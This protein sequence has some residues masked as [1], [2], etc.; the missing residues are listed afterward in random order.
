[1]TDQGPD[2][3]SRFLTIF[4]S[5]MVPMFLAVVDQT[6]VAA[7]L[8]AI[9]SSLGGVDRLSWVVVAYL[10]A[11]TIAAPVYGRLGDV[12]GRRRL[13]L[14]ALAIFIT[15]SVLCALARSI[16]M[17]TAARVLQG[18]GG[19][20]LMTLSQA[21]VG[22]AIPP[23]ERARYQ[24]YLAAVAVTASAFGPVVG[25]V[26]TELLG[27]RSIFLVNLPMGLGAVLLVLR[28]PARVGSGE[29]FRFDFLGLLLFATLVA[30]TLVLLE[31][32]QQIVTASWLL[33]ALL[34]IGA[35]AA[36]LLLIRREARV[37][38]PLLPLPLLRDPA[39]WRCDALAACHGATL[40]SLITFLP[41]YFRM[42]HGASPAQI[43]LLLLPLTIGIGIGSLVTGRI[44][45]RTGRSAIFPSVGL[46][47]VVLVLAGIA[48]AS[49]HLTAVQIGWAFG[50]CA[51]FMG[52]V[53]GVVQLTVQ[54]AAG[55]R[56]LGAGAASVQFS[57][58]LGAAIGTA[59]VGTVLF[60]T[61]STSTPEARDVFASILRQGSHGVPDDVSLR[62]PAMLGL[63][64]AFRGAFL[65]SSCFAAVGACLAWSLPIRRV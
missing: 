63:E 56:Q 16:E 17:L 38:W 14:V 12:L 46:T 31:Q 22:E 48:F 44:I 65:C 24:G 60:S 61:F 29:A 40:V 35:I 52:T 57:R 36:G 18:A 10:V 28:L 51:I 15:A 5:I 64:R 21:L 50:F 20:G 55:A 42:I 26:M 47:V 27:W 2:S 25:G 33:P 23:R 45:G 32:V 19:G 6:V 39:I 37:P 8:P 34:S 49:S 43:G 13:L 41:L 1:M 7:A 9:A 54:L 62:D 58:S 30:S 4:P 11:T 59:L 3:R 53:M